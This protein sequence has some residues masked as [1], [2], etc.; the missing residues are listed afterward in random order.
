MRLEFALDSSSEQPV[1]LPT[2]RP[3]ASA[4]YVVNRGLSKSASS[5][6]MTS[7]SWSSGARPGLTCPRCTNRVE[8]LLAEVEAEPGLHDVFVRGGHQDVLVG[9]TRV[10]PRRRSDRI[11]RPDDGRAAR[12]VSCRLHPDVAAPQRRILRDP[13]EEPDERPA[14]RRRPGRGRVGCE[15]PFDLAPRLAARLVCGVEQGLCQPV[16]AMPRGEE[17]SCRVEIPRLEWTDL[18][19]SGS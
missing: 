9:S 7:S 19:T 1:A 10:D 6:A 13:D 5:S 15:Q 2:T 11:Q 4:T 17:S 14:R 12:G 8:V 18:D 3:P 16:P